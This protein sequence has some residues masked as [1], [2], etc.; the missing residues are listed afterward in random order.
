MG[1]VRASVRFLWVWGVYTDKTAIFVKK[2]LGLPVMFFLQDLS[3]ISSKSRF[4]ELVTAVSGG[5]EHHKTVNK[6]KY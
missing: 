2:G 1:R 3:E 5:K 4:R 6:G